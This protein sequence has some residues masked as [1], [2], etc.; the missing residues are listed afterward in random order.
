MDQNNSEYGHF[1][2]SE[3]PGVIARDIECNYTQI[4][5]KYCLFSS[6]K[7]KCI[8]VYWYEGN[9]GISTEE[10]DENEYMNNLDILKMIVMKIIT[11]TVRKI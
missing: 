3:P 1:S 11:I 8:Y 10:S 2:R 9:C 5:D 4:G 6:F 7:L